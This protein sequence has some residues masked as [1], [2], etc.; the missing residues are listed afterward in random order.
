MNHCLC[1]Q[2]IFFLPSEG[3][4]T[5]LTF[6]THKASI[7]VRNINRLAQGVCQVWK[8]CIP[9][10]WHR[11]CSWFD[12]PMPLQRV[13]GWDREGPVEITTLDVLGL[14]GNVFIYFFLKKRLSFLSSRW[15]FYIFNLAAVWDDMQVQCQQGSKG[16]GGSNLVQTTTKPKLCSFPV[17]NLSTEFL[18]SPPRWLL[19]WYF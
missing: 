15:T 9:K 11:L 3:T 10:V 16:L 18:F 8:L 6:N 13:W 1:L 4:C 2:F 7:E 14:E 17:C 5:N 19:R 12:F